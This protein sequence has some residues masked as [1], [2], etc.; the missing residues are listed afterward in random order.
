MGSFFLLVSCR[1]ES[2]I[3]GVASWSHPNFLGK[4]FS[5]SLPSW[6]LFFSQNRIV[7]YMPFTDT[8]TH[9][10]LSL[11]LKYCPC[12]ITRSFWI[13]FKSFFQLVTLVAVGKKHL[14][15]RKYIYVNPN[16]PIYP[17]P[18]I[19][20]YPYVC[21]L[22]LCLCFCSVKKIAYTSFFF[23]FCIHWCVYISISFSD[24]FHS[25]WQ[26]I[27]PFTSYKIDN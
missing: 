5:N 24:L 22:L 14:T 10:H 4:F 7:T 2:Q 13:G 11:G 8:H 27:D 12:R 19:P 25:V 16:L 9:T 17:P 1:N 15:L 3:F 6:L 21:S 26:S 18:F 20:C 23:R